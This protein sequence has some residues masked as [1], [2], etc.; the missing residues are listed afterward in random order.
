MTILAVDLPG[1]DG[2]NAGVIVEQGR[3][4]KA[5]PILRKFVGQLR[6]NLERWARRIG[7]EVK[8]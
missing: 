6:A 3:I 1:Q 4:V 2:F 7:A 8:G 5:A